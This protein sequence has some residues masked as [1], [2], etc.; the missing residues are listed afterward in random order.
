MYTVIL[1]KPGEKHL[2]VL[3]QLVV[4]QLLSHIWLF[5]APWIAALQ[6]SLS[7]TVSQ[8]LLKRMSIELVM[9]SNSSSGN[10][11]LGLP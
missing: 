4:V 1:W 2:I 11:F 9:P 5:A 8:S 10:F 3:K 6:S 7:F